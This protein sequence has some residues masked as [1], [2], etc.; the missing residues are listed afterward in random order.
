LNGNALNGD[1]IAEPLTA[2]NLSRTAR[3]NLTDNILFEGIYSAL[4]D[5]MGAFDET[6]PSTWFN[7]TQRAKMGGI[8]A[9]YYQAYLSAFAPSAYFNANTTA[10]VATGQLSIPVTRALISRL[11]ATALGILLLLLSILLSHALYKQRHLGPRHHVYRLRW[12]TILTHVMASSPVLDTVIRG[13]ERRTE[14]D[15]K[16]ILEGMQ[17]RLDANGR[18]DVV[19]SKGNQFR[20]LDQNGLI[21]VVEKPI[22]ADG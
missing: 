13:C 21:A 9:V 10:V 3:A 19:D 12:C 18:I 8:I 16:K 14:S 20:L 6:Q 17:F 5:E 15:I 7:E 4:I 11:H 2:G 22:S 1:D